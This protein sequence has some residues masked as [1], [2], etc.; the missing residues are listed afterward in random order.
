MRPLVAVALLASLAVPGSVS[1]TAG[2]S[3]TRLLRTPS[4]S[5]T[6][7]AFVYANN[8]WV[9]ERKVATPDG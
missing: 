6:H 8:I 7:V 2:G 3:P 9:V 1:L 4:I 5:A